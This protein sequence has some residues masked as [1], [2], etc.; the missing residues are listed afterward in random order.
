M[1]I[2]GKEP[3]AMPSLIGH[4]STSEL[5][6]ANLLP[7][8]LPLLRGNYPFFFQRA[9]GPLPWHSTTP[10]PCCCRFKL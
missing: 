5:G 8:L 6:M 2:L 3:E 10:V 7:S 1:W 4:I 9:A